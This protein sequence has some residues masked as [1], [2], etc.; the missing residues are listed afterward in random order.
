MQHSQLVNTESRDLASWIRRLWVSG[1]P[2]DCDL[3]ESTIK[4]LLDPGQNDEK[5]LYPNSLDIAETLCSLDV[6]QTTIMAALLSDPYFEQ[7]LELHE[8]TAEYGQSVAK[9]CK[10]M[11]EL[12]HF[13]ECTGS[14]PETFGEKQQAEQVRR[15]LL[16]MLDDIR[17]VLI[18]LSWHLQYLRLL[19]HSEIG[20]K[21]VC[22]ARQ[23][24]E[25]YAPITNRLGV[26]HMKWEMED[27]AFRFQEPE[28]YQSIARS[29][30]NTRLEREN[31][32][33]DFL[34][35]IKR[36]M[37]DAGINV[38]VYGR[39][40]H[41]Y[42]I[43]K[44]MKRKNVGIAQLY[45][46]RAIRIIVDD[47]KTCYEVLSMV[48]EKWPF[49]PEEWDDYISKRK[50]NGYQSIHT[51]VIGPRGRHVEI[52][53]RTEKMHQFAELGVAAH[54]RYKENTN[55]DPALERVVSSL[56]RLLDSD[57]E[58]SEFLEDFHT[59][60][61]S[62]RVFIMT[63]RGRVLDLAKGATP[64]DFAYAIHTN[65]GHRCQGAKVNG[66]IVPLNYELSNGE[67]VEILT[68]KEDNPKLNW[69][70]DSLG[71]VKS[72]RTKQKINHWFSQQNH[73]KNYQNGKGILER[74]KH[75]LNLPKLK[76][77]DLVKPFNRQSERDVLIAL[78]RGDI[79]PKQ[80]AGTLIRS[81]TEEIRFRRVK[82][83]DIAKVSNIIVNGVEDLYTQIANCCQPVFGDN[84][85]GYITQG[86]GISV[87]RTD[88][89]N[90]THVA[91]EQQNRLVDVNWGASSTDYAADIMV[92]G[93]NQPGMLRDIAE[94]L[95]KE[96]INVISINTRPAQDSQYSLMEIAIQI[97]DTLQLA[98]IL[99]RLIQ[100]PSVTDA[101]RR[102]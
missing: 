76:A 5:S 30:Q 84:I 78:G 101:Q 69:L 45:D 24:M 7:T 47:E 21:H 68:G 55:Q 88:C 83:K 28:K 16:A 53:I 75:I 10:N 13:S 51:V 100:L 2:A 44:K 26:S 82:K 61:F 4:V 18:K 36:M 12:Y 97:S 66:V 70:N 74:E 35:L 38:Q 43:W 57:A 25:V 60:L 31:Y 19:S 54:W 62:D 49:I 91:K 87:H 86:R 95:A 63:P 77:S 73:E 92:S 85:V 41:I 39:P 65:I 27:L 17:A 71:Y 33:E 56:R 94:V 34:I 22:A 23:T 99:E 80:L 1:N 9:L 14:N 96:K 59:E 3:L 46:L 50:P 98:D 6:D 32:I 58:D 15:M 93:Y 8:I 90:I 40:K 102:M 29:L 52:Q 79:T 11:R 42:S 81:Q 20:D 64:L 89:T 48:H 67:Q 72:A 37:H